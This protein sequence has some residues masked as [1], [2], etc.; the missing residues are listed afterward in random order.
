[1]VLIDLYFGDRERGI[2]EI[3]KS[4]EAGSS[5]EGA[6]QEMDPRKLE[7]MGKRLNPQ[8]IAEAKYFVTSPDQLIA[9]IE[10]YQKAGATHVDLVTNS[11]PERITFIGEKVLPY[12]EAK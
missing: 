1:M 3:Q 4:G 11:F 9:I 5:A 10:S 6:F 12:F 8:K 7:V 2:L